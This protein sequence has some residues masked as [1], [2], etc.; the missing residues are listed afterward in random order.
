MKPTKEY[1]D[2]VDEE[3]KGY[4]DI[5]EKEIKKYLKSD[6]PLL[7]EAANYLIKAGGKRIRPSFIFL[8]YKSV[9]GENIDEV[10]PISA[11]IEFIHTAS[12]IHDDIND[13]SEVR[14]GTAATHVAF[15]PIK[16][17]VA[18]DFLFVKA[19]EIG[20]RYDYEIIKII[21]RACTNLAEGEILQNEIKGKTDVD[22]KEY[23]NIISKKTASLISAC[24]EIGAVL[25]KAKPIWRS[26]LREFG[27][28]IGLAFQIVDDVLDI[29]GEKEKTG[30]LRGM[31]LR[32]GQISLPILY[33]LKELEGEEKKFLKDVIEKKENDDEE[34]ERAISLIKKSKAVERSYE[35]AMAF[36]N[37]A[38]ELIFILPASKYRDHFEIVVEYIIQ[39]CF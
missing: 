12:L 21:G 10:L 18:G 39:R 35:T 9:G 4:L 19:F 15:G 33:A 7:S 3:L 38:K 32:E 37:K 29:L 30:K 17:L 31:D 5:L 6:A 25:G 22:K 8:A 13:H 1:L 20:G 34:I 36:A 14:R 26:S 23:L 11:A 16:A 28:N 27:I 2:F 24:L